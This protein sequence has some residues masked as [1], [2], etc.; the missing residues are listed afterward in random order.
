MT[1]DGPVKEKYI[2][3]KTSKNSAFSSYKNAIR[4]TEVQR[5]TKDTEEEFKD[6]EMQ[7]N[8]LKVNRKRTHQEIIKDFQ[9]QNSELLFFPNENFSG[10]KRAKSH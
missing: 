8:E 6:T 5:K 3:L 4:T 1:I 7:I 10:R 9:T 2:P